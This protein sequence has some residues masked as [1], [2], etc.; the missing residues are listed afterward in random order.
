LVEKLIKEILLKPN[1]EKTSNNIDVVY[2]TRK[3]N[4]IELQNYKQAI[5]IDSKNNNALKYLSVI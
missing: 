2:F 3:S 5:T 4:P 1:F